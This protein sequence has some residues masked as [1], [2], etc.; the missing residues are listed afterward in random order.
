MMFVR[1]LVCAVAL[2][3]LLVLTDAARVCERS[4]YCSIG[5]TSGYIGP[6]DTVAQLKDAL[7]ATAFKQELIVFTE[8]R[9]H[10]AAQFLYRFRSA[11]YDHVLTVMEEMSQCQQL[12]AVFQSGMSE[13]GPISC[14]TYATTDSSGVSYPSKFEYLGR[15]VGLTAWWRKW[16]TVGRALALGYNVI[17]ADTDVLVLDDWY[18]RAKQPPLSQYNMLCQNEV[19]VGFNSGFC[20]FQNVSSNGPIVW[21]VFEAM[22]RVVRW[23]EDDSV[24]VATSDRYRQKPDLPITEQF[25]LEE[26]VHSAVVG[27]PM[28]FNLLAIYGRGV[29]GAEAF[30]KMGTTS[31]EM[32]TAIQTSV[33]AA[34]EN[35]VEHP[36]EGELAEA[37]C[38]YYM[39]PVCNTSV[40]GKV[41]MSAANLKMP[42]SGGNWPPQF[43]GYPFNRSI[44]PRTTA[45]RRAYADLG[46]PLPPDP[47]DPATEAAARAIKPE[48]FGYLAAHRSGENCLGCWAQSTWW[49]AGRH[50][51]WHTH[52]RQQ[53]QETNN[54]KTAA[55][56]NVAL[57]HIWAGL[58]PGDSQKDVVLMLTGHYS[59][60]LAVRTARGRRYFT[61][62]H[63]PRISPP[64]VALLPEVRNVVAFQPGVIHAG[65]S[66][67]QF[68]K[69]AQ[70]LAQVAVTL[71]AIAAWPAVPCDSDWALKPEVRNTIQRPITK[72]SIPWSRYLDVFFQV[73]PFGDSL[74]ELQCEWPA[75]TNIDCLAN[76]QPAGK[77]VGH[78][79]LAV[80]FHHLR[81]NHTHTHDDTAH[82]LHAGSQHGP[83]SGAKRVDPS[84]ATTLLLGNPAPPLAPAGNTERQPVEHTDL[85]RLNAQSILMRQQRESMPV[86][87]L[88]RLVEVVGMQG[89]A[90]EI[91]NRWY[92]KCRALSYYDVPPQDR[93]LW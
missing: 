76:R 84:P 68:I 32:F 19:G 91:Y 75:F 62:Q 13:G 60:Q 40:A 64:H 89:E 56:N 57:G 73:Q 38:E 71:G 4:G 34:W 7:A 61:N 29:E 23:A 25:M 16:F 70:G 2:V 78:G 52:L 59:W 14:G 18:W 20:Y 77:E 21:L 5:K 49:A 1:L 41:L 74:E 47:E 28:F 88:D 3:S 39:A 42:H 15:P 45:Y 65:M 79:M 83:H 87:W 9:V 93:T 27:R 58:F 11:G 82:L 69:A 31:L 30:R 90:A 12:R 55:P 48:R 26:C 51:W 46:V 10:D 6:L 92:G 36:I 35:Y 54:K 44:G 80:E 43:G 22:H 8:T 63:L 66:K 50:G 37:V 33:S 86:F 72:H 53:Q 24:L 17:S 81:K 67:E 85:L